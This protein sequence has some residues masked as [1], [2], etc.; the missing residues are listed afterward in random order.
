[1]IFLERLTLTYAELQKWMLKFVDTSILVKHWTIKFIQSIVIVLTYIPVKRKKDFTLHLFFFK[2]YYHTF[3]LRGNH[4]TSAFYR[5]YCPKIIINLPPNFVQKFLGREDVMRHQLGIWNEIWSDVITETHY[6]R[7]GKGPQRIIGK[8]TNQRV[9][10]IWTE[11]YHSTN[12]YLKKLREI[13]NKKK[14]CVNDS[15]RERKQQI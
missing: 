10:N 14:V 1:M 9:I 4:Y 11:I 5:W 2:K 8:T 7:H 6:M 15:K 12:A 13:R 3:F